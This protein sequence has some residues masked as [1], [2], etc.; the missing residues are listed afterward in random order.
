MR[1]RLPAR[2]LCI[3]CCG[4]IIRRK[5]RAV[6]ALSPSVLFVLVLLGRDSFN[7]VEYFGKPA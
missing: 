1:Y 5:K 4:D 6:S 2:L 7:L 3:L